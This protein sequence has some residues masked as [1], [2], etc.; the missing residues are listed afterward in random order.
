MGHNKDKA[1]KNP[2]LYRLFVYK[3]HMS[4]RNTEHT[5]RMVLQI[6]E[7]EYALGMVP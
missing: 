3:E 1:S 4:V 5:H 2:Y 6:S 7:T